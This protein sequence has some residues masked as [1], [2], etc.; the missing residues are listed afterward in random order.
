MRFACTPTVETA[1][2]LTSDVHSIFPNP[3][4][5]GLKISGMV[6]QPFVRMVA[7]DGRV[8]HV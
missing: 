4:T 8:L 2:V 3:A 7:M 1:E 5:N 6:G